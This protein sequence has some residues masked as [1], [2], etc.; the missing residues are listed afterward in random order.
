M[1]II[2]AAINDAFCLIDCLR[3]NTFIRFDSVPPLYGGMM[4]NSIG[5]VL[6][7]RIESGGLLNDFGKLFARAKV[8]GGGS[9]GEAGSMLVMYRSVNLQIL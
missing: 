7:F 1:I 5:C 2:I 6:F 8:G 3:C 9:I 4:A